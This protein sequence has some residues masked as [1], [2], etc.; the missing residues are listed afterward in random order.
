MKKKLLNPLLCHL[1]RPYL[2]N[3]QI[4][5]IIEFLKTAYEQ[6]QTFFKNSQA[7]LNKELALLQS[8]ISKLI[9][10]QLDEK[11]DSNTYHTKLEEYQQRQRTLT[12][13]I[14]TYKDAS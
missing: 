9:D 11:I 5:E 4:E 10:M 7:A 2:S 3:Q 8:R 14:K 1:E 12:A 13:E 6:D